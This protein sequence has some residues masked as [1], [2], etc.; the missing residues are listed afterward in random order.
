MFEFLR[1]ENITDPEVFPSSDIVDAASKLEISE[2]DLFSKAY[3]HQYGE[4]NEGEVKKAFDIYFDDTENQIPFWARDYAR[5]VLN[6]N[7]GVTGN[8]QA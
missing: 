3:E 6:D 1:E 2:Y 7:P 8:F 5:K 4:Q